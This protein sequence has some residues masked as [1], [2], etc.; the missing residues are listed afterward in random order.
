MFLFMLISFT[1]EE[2]IQPLLEFESLHYRFDKYLCARFNLTEPYS[3]YS[4]ILKLIG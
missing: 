4:D 2:E 1:Q 3:Q